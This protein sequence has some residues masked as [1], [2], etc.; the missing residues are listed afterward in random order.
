[1][2]LLLA[3]AG[4][5]AEPSTTSQQSGERRL[6]ESLRVEQQARWEALGAYFDSVRERKAEEVVAEVKEALTEA[7]DAPD[8]P[9]V[10]RWKRRAVRALT[11]QRTTETL[12]RLSEVSW[13]RLEEDRARL[14]RAAMA[15]RAIRMEMERVRLEQEEE[16]ELLLLAA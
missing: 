10:Q 8:T 4:A 12:P 2:G 5:E 11:P 9:A 1:M 7:K 14:A 15:F 6:A 3:I 16:E 13:L